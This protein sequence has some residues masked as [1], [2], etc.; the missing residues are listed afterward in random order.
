MIVVIA[1]LAYLAIAAAHTAAMEWVF[2]DSAPW[3]TLSSLVWPLAA[4]FI[5]VKLGVSHLIDKLE[6]KE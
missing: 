1:I 4:P 2:E 6:G 3:M 5:W